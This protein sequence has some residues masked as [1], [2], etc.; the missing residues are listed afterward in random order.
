MMSRLQVMRNRTG[1][2]KGDISGRNSARVLD[3]LY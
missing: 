3:V 2:S 1:S